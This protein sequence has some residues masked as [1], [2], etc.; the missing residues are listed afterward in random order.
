MGE[1]VG[2]EGTSIKLSTGLALSVIVQ[3]TLSLSFTSLL[4]LYS[5][6][7][8]SDLSLPLRSVS[9][10]SSLF[11][12]FP[13]LRLSLLP[14][15]SSTSLLFLRGLLLSSTSSTPSAS[16]KT[17]SVRSTSAEIDRLP[18]HETLRRKRQARGLE[19]LVERHS[20]PS[21]HSG[22]CPD[23]PSPLVYLQYNAR[24]TRSTKARYRSRNLRL[25]ST[26]TIY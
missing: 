10:T 22:T 12:G 21:L 13:Y 25:S 5:L 16:T 24:Q 19:W 15:E 6:S 14:T 1:W 2:V 11:H 4:A 26:K 17:A 18:A 3:K 23:S 8:A 7:S 9:R 20:D